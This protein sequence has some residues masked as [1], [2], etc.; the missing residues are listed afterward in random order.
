MLPT[1]RNLRFRLAPGSVAD[2]HVQGP[3][4]TQFANAMSISFPSGERFF[5]HAVRHYRDRITD[6]A[7]QEAMTAFIGQEAMHS[8]EHEDYNRLLD[9][10]GLPA[11]QLDAFNARCLELVKRWLPAAAQLSVTIAQEHFTAIVS[12]LMLTDARILQGADPRLLALW[13]WHALEEIEHKA[14]AFDVYEAVMGR[15]AAAYALRIGGL[16][17]TTAGFL[18]IVMLYQQVLL[19]AAPQR[20]SWRGLGQFIRFMTL[21]PALLPRLARLARPWLEYFDPGFH[22]WNHDNRELLVRMDAV[23]AQTDPVRLAVY[24]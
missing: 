18:G 16:L 19:R 22:P 7:L 6:P 21:S 5:I 12:E 11:A 14:V 15:N 20:R 13:H 3:Y 4:V 9:Q 10:A 24:G 2:W 1:R 23:L 8:R 17:A